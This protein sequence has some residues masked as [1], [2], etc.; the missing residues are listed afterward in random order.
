M[1][2]LTLSV[3]QFRI[4]GNT[5]VVIEMSVKQISKFLIV[6][7]LDFQFDVGAVVGAARVL[8]LDSVLLGHVVSLVGLVLEVYQVFDGVPDAA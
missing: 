4:T 1:Y 7:T 6:Q 2:R 3:E 5:A 8:A